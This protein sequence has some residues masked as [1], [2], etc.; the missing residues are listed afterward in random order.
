M[1][2]SK[3]SLLMLVPCPATERVCMGESVLD[4]PVQAVLS[5]PHAHVLQSRSDVLQQGMY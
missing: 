4:R 1:S 5:L 3:C 2:Q